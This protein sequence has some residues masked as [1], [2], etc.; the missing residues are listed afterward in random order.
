MLAMGGNRTGAE[1]P[2]GSLS[3]GRGVGGRT[4]ATH[5]LWEPEDT[6][7]YLLAAVPGSRFPRHRQSRPQVISTDQELVRG[8]RRHPRPASPHHEPPFPWLR[9]VHV[10][11]EVPQASP[12]LWDHQNL[13][14]SHG[15]RHFWVWHQE[16][17]VNGSGHRSVFWGEHSTPPHTLLLWD[18]CFG[19]KYSW[20]CGSGRA[21]TVRDRQVWKWGF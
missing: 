10:F 3:H 15:F 13:T 11:G 21:R 4:E 7:G 5:R 20:S 17:P 18:S 19:G 14:H 2:P 9:R 1:G 6:P 16:I 12:F 8:Y